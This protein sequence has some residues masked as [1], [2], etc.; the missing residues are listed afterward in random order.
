MTYVIFTLMRQGQ[1]RPS[2]FDDEQDAAQDQE[3][4]Q[5]CMPGE[6]FAQDE[7][8][9]DDA[10]DGDDQDGDAG[11]AGFHVGEDIIP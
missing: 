8:T 4:A 10:D 5:G 6:G 9:A 1:A 11:L 3:N 2:G 7:D